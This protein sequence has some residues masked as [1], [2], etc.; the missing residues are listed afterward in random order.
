MHKINNRARLFA[1]RLERKTELEVK[2][3]FLLQLNSDRTMSITGCNNVSFCT[4]EEILL[5]CRYGIVR[6]RGTDLRIPVFSE[7]DT[8]IS[9]CVTD[10]A[11][12]WEV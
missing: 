4:T 8:V 5:Q 2:E 11:F 6:V 12:F 1:D 3:S 7:S 9:G 10:I